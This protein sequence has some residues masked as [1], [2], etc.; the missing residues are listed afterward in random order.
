M[1]GATS[2]IQLILKKWGD[3]AAGAAKE[4][5]EKVGF[6]ESVANRIATGELP[7]DE[8]SRVARREARYADEGLVHVNRGGIEGEGFD[9]S[10]LPTD[11]PDTPF[12]AHWFTTDPHPTTAFR[13]QGSDDPLT[14]TPVVLEKGR[15]GDWRDVV[16]YGESMGEDA[17]YGTEFREGL[18]DNGVSDIVVRGGDRIDQATIDALPVDGRLKIDPDN[19]YGDRRNSLVKNEDGSL[20]FYEGSEHILDYDDLADY[21]RFNPE[22][23][24]V[25]VL[26]NTIIRSPNAAF[27]PQYTGSN[28]MGG[29]AGTAGL[30]GLLS[31]GQSE[32]ADAGI[33]APLKLAKRLADLDPK[34]DAHISERPTGLILDKLV[35]PEDARGQGLGGELMERLTTYADEEGQKVALTAA[36][37]FGGSRSGQERFYRRHGF[38]PNKG[39]NKDFEFTENMVR[40]PSE[41]GNADPRLLAGTAAGTAGLL[42]AP[43]MADKDK[44][45]PVPTAGDIGESILS[46]LGMPMTGLQGIGRG[47]FGLATGEGLTEAAAQAGNTMD[48]GWKDGRVD[49]SGINPDKGADQ[50]EEY[51]TEKTGDEALGWMAKMGLLLGGI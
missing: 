18:L 7:M 42:A 37:D 48:V 51:V 15:R 11:D 6:P 2:I 24:D 32:D 36:G 19:K 41:R 25:A 46:I 39:R 49:V 14:Y 35:V 45:L 29:A 47:L 3:D 31:A 40:T 34:M 12:N 9:N 8:A 27:D 30:A 1:A 43:L 13:K 4:L 26:D 17:G 5:E 10:R 20:G 22:I 16:N 44:P 21:Q 50:L 38:M 23:K 28:I 33:S